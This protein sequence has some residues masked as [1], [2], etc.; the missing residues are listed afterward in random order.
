MDE[1]AYLKVKIKSLAEEA[2][3]IRKEEKRARRKSIRMGL[4]DHRKGI[5]RTEARHTHLAYGF[6]RG[7]DYHQME[8][9]TH[10]APNWDKV[11]KMVEKYGTHLDWGSEDCGYGDH[12]ARKEE[13]RQRFEVWLT[14]AQETTKV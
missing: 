6:L 1:R 4:A 14:K 9:S 2:R 8:S 3:I 10:E 13:V 5:V 11:R 12:K 7:R